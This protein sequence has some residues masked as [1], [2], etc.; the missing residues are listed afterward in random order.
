MSDVLLCFLFV[1]LFLFFETESCS[2][3]QAEVQWHDFS[4]PQTLPPGSSN[5]RASA[6]GVARITRAHH[7]AQLIFVFL[8]ETGFHH[9]GQ[10]SR[11]LLTSSNPP[12]SSSQCVGITGMNH[13]AHLYYHVLSYAKNASRFIIVR[14]QVV[15]S[16]EEVNF[17]VQIHSHLKLTFRQLWKYYLKSREIS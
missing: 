9:V 7:H 11:K 4:S 15:I 8:V 12:T 6:S 10:A 2:I 3:T 14:R 13:P 1:C 17:L 16:W 5:F